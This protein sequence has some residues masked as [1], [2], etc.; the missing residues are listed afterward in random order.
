M[1][2]L[3]DP[4]VRSIEEA[5]LFPRYSYQ[6]LRKEAWKW[7]LQEFLSMDRNISLEG[8]GLLG[9]VLAKPSIPVVPRALTEPPRNLSLIHI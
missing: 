7:I 1:Q 3:V 5:E 9:F 4:L 6:Q 2:D 8:L